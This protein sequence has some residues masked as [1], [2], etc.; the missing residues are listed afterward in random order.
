MNRS[1]GKSGGKDA[2]SERTSVPLSLPPEELEQLRTVM[3]WM[4]QDPE[5]KKERPRFQTAVRY[6]LAYTLANPPAHV[7]AAQG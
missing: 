6:A 7:R 3:G 5:W 2:A 1:K 4:L